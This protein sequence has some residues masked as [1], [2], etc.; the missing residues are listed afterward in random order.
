MTIRS[1]FF[2]FGAAAVLSACGGGGGGSSL[3]PPK[4]GAVAPGGSLVAA[5][6]TPKP[7]PTI[8][9]SNAHD[10]LQGGVAI[11]GGDGLIYAV[12]QTG[13]EQYTQALQVTNAAA[14]AVPPDTWP[15]T[16]PKLKPAASLFSSGTAMNALATQPA[17]TP[18]AATSNAANPTATFPVYVALDTSSH[19]WGGAFVDNEAGNLFQDFVRGPYPEGPGAGTGGI[20]IIGDKPN[21]NGYSGF[22]ASP[23]GTCAP[24]PFSFAFLTQLINFQG[25]DVPISR[26]TFDENGAIWVAS[27]PS[28]NKNKTNTPSEL[29]QID[30]VFDQVMKQITLPPTSQVNGMV[31]GPDGAIWFTDSGLNKIGRVSGG[32][33]QYS[34][35][36]PTPGA[37][38]ERITVDALGNLWFTELHGNKVGRIVTSVPITS[39]SAITE[40]KVPTANSHPHG[41]IG[42]QSGSPCPS[43]PDVNNV[44]FT[45]D[46]NI[47]KV[48]Q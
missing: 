20:W 11:G 41:I 47:A 30:I 25:P 37:V 9:E 2:V 46:T 26:G 21:S 4:A 5:A 38:P 19:I 43:G 17:T 33:V 12:G 34:N 13:L 7:S 10:T 14:V 24:P 29:I 8:H 40:F 15:V 23:N 48:I 22:L 1:V 36:L 39:P 31:L 18:G 3:L 35:A 6:P 44:F 28:L 42:C 27:D 16:N 32:T 45:E